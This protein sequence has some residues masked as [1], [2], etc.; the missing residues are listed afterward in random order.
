VRRFRGDIGIC[1]GY[2]LAAL[3]LLHHLWRDPAGTM[4]ADNA[5]DQTL[6]EWMLSNAARSLTRLDN[7]LFTVR[8][9]APDGVNLM[10][11]TSVLALAF[12][13]APV[14]LLFGSA[15]TFLILLTVAFAGTA[16]AWYYLLS[17]RLVGSRLAAAAGGAFAGFAPA[18]IS[19][20]TG[21]PH[22]ADQFL[23]P[24]IVLAVGSLPDPGR[25]SVY[26]GLTLAGLIIAQAFISEEVLL[27]T[28]LGLGV[29]L[30]AYWVPP[31]RIRS[32]LPALGVAVL[33]TGVVMA[34]PLWLQFAG[35][36][37]YHGLPGF[38]RGYGADL[39]GYPAFARRSLF[40]DLHAVEKLGQG[41]TEETTF[42]GWPLLIVAGFAAIFL[43]SNRIARAVTVTGV[44][45]GALS[46]GSDVHVGGEA[47]GVTGPWKLLS[48]LPLFD[49]VV[50]TRLAL[51]LTPLIA[52][53]IALILDVDPPG[54]QAGAR[55]RSPAAI[56]ET[57]DAARSQWTRVRLLWTTA[58]C[59]AL[60][61]ILPTPLPAAPRPY[62]PHF[63]RS[64]TW[65]R[66]VPAGG[67][68]VPVPM[69]WY[70]YLDAMR[71][72]T[73]ADLDFAIVGGY[74]LGPDPNRTDREAIFGPGGSATGQLLDEASRAPVAPTVDSGQLATVREE[75]HRFHATTLV[76]PDNTGNAD[77]LRGVVDQ[78]AGPGTH[79]DDVWLWDLR[80]TV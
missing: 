46:L 38:V 12:P 47:T 42:F 60:V 1:A 49:S 53:L 45:F 77:V 29:F 13:L 27:L 6:F 28:A 75:L 54:Y 80:S 72:S 24:F 21:H 9:N 56:D 32:A 44:V 43:L 76:M 52:V 11:N 74:F 34:Y 41:P 48:G 50:P 64:G 58:V 68:V 67:T 66:Y 10:A 65:Q 2:L 63:F 22:I 7:P 57:S 51:I 20:A 61:P 30:L 15:V 40:G 79:V 70:P 71:W 31:A 78:V 55:L 4:L 25:R 59:V 73:T 36:Q 18:M 19:Q 17:R 14:T 69:G 3:F 37:S 5:Q 8:L 16:A 39:A 33:V 35:P 23:V 26:K 62:V